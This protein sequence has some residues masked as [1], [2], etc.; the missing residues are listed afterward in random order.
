MIRHLTASAV[1]IDPN[2]EAVLL[3]WHRA[4][5]AWMFPGGH[6]DPDESPAEAAVR[7]VQE[8]TGLAATLVGRPF[9]LPEQTWQA[10]PFLTAEI[11][12]PAK[13]ERPGKPAEAAHSHIDQLFLATAA[14]TDETTRP[15]LRRQRRTDMAYKV[16]YTPAGKKTRDLVTDIKDRGRAE[17]HRAA[18]ASRA[19]KGD[20]VNVEKNGGKS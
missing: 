14:P 9:D 7:E 1:V 20:T 13:P 10:S 16:T 17:Q 15:P 4:S 12:A 19:A 3:V 8:E 11:P 5:Q 18:Y 6:V 2:T